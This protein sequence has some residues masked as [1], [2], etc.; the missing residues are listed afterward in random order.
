MDEWMDEWMDYESHELQE[1]MTLVWVVFVEVTR[2]Y[3]EGVSLPV[4]SGCLRPL[5][6]TSGHVWKRPCKH[7]PADLFLF[8]LI[9]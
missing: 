9:Y 4:I 7:A 8:H 2:C 6:T 5:P 3:N 1:V